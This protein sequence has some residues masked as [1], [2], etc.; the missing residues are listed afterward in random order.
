MGIE[1]GDILAHLRG[2]GCEL[3]RVE[4]MGDAFELRDRRRGLKVALQRGVK[5]GQC[6]DAGGH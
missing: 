6:F 5:I 1:F 4:A 2:Q 3:N